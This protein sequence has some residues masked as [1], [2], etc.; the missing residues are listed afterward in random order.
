MRSYVGALIPIRRDDCM[1]AW[2]FA[3]V[4]VL[5]KAKS[6]ATGIPALAHFALSWT[7]WAAT[8]SIPLPHQTIPVRYNRQLPKLRLCRLRL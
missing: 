7:P 1:I 4:G 8:A 3:V 6:M 5:A 2:L